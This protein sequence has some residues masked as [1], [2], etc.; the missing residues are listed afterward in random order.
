MKHAA[1]F[2]EGYQDRAF[3]NQWLELRGLLRAPKQPGKGIFVKVVP[4][5]SELW[6]L[7]T[8][9][10][11]GLTSVFADFV[12]ARG[13]DFDE[14]LVVNDSDLLDATEAERR[15][16]QSLQTYVPKDAVLSVSCW[17]PRLESVIEQALR[18]TTQIDSRPS[19]SFWRRA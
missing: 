15:I 10:T 7:N 17:Q 16:F 1:I 9:G 6:L 18:E 4:G 3:I 14:F 19:T 2:V 8:E 12:A 13:D 11:S 5:G